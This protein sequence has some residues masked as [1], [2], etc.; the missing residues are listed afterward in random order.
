M[1]FRL[2]WLWC[3]RN[4]TLTL[5]RLP[6][7]SPAHPVLSRPK[8]AI[9][10]FL[11]TLI[12]LI[13][14]P[15]LLLMWLNAPT[16]PT[17]TPAEAPKSHRPF[18]A[19][20]PANSP[21]P[22]VT[23]SPLQIPPPTANTTRPP[24][25]ADL[26]E[27]TGDLSVP[28]NR[29]KVVQQMREIERSR[30]IETVAEAQKRG[31]P[32][33][34]EHPN[35]K[36]QELAGF[37]NGQPLYFTTHNLNA[38]ISTGANVL[39]LSP[40]SLQ[41]SGIT[42]GMWDGGSGRATHQEFSA[43]SR[44][45]VKDGAP[46]IDHATHVGGTLAAA[47][48]NSSAR[49]MAPAAIVDSYDWNS[50]KSEMTARAAAAPNEEG[51]LYLSNHSYGFVSGWNYVGGS[52]SPSRLWE[53]YG[54][55]TTNTGYEFDFGRY[56]TLSRDSDALAF[57]APYYLMFRSAGNDRTE[58][59]SNG[60][61]V[62]LS[63][64]SSTVV[65]YDSTAHPAGDG[66]YRGGFDTIGFDSLAKNVVTVGSV[67]DAVTNG[68]RDPSK[69]NS[70]SFSSWGPTD[71][72]RIKPDLVANGDGVFSSLNGSNT[73]YGTY[74]GTSMSAPNAT[75]TAALLIEEYRR[76]FPGNDMRSSSLKALLIHTADDLGRPGPD[77]KFGW[78]LINGVA[79][80]DLIRDHA[81]NPLKLRLTEGLITSTA[82]TINH[83]FVWDGVS[84]IQATLCWTDPAGTATTT[85]ELRTPRLRNDLDL[86]IIGPT[87][88]EHLPYVMPFVGTW[89]QASMDQAATTGRNN[90]D[91]VE[92]VR[93]TSPPAPGVYRCVVTF[94]GTLANNQQHYSL[95][96]SGS[97]SEQPPPPPL[98][99]SSINPNSAY[100]IA[101]QAELTGT[102]FA[103]DT[104]IKLTR[105][106][107]PDIIATNL[108]LVSGKLRCQLNLASAT[109]GLWDVWVAN[110]DGET[111]SLPAAFT[112]LSS[113]WTE[114]LDGP[115]SGWSSQ[116]TTG[117]NA[118]TLSTAA[119]HSP[120][121]AYFAPGPASKTTCHLTSPSIPIPAN[122]TNLQLKFWHQY[123]LQAGQDGGRLAFSVDNGA[124]FDVLATDSGTTF[125]SNGY[126][127][128][129][130]SGGRPA[131]RS[132]FAGLRA[133]SGSSSGFIETVVNFTNNA[134][135]AGKNL[136]LRFSLATNGGV[137]SQGWSVDSLTLLGGS[138]VSNQAPTI[139]SP[140]AA[141]TSTLPPEEDGT[142]FYQVNGQSVAV[143]V[144]ANDD[145]GEAAL[146][147]TW[148]GSS[149]T[150]PPV[151]FSANSTN[152]AKN[153][154]ALF[155]GAG[156][157]LL[158]VTVEDA[159]GLAASSNLNLRV[160]PVATSIAVTPAVASVVFG[161]PFS[162]GAQVLDQFGS[163][164]SSQPSSFQWT[165]NGGGTLSASGTF[166]ATAAGGPYVI[167]ATSGSLSGI[168][169][170][171]VTPAPAGVFLTNLQQPFDGQPKPVTVTTSPAGLATAIS[172]DGSPTAPTEA[173]SYPVEALITDPNYQGA[174]NATLV[175]DPPTTLTFSQWAS[176]YDLEPSDPEG[177]SDGD[178]LAN[179]LEYALGTNPLQPS[180]PIQIGIEP[181]PRRSPDID[182]RFAFQFNRPIGL[183]NL[184][185]HVMATTNLTDWTEVTD[186]SITE[187]PAEGWETVTAYDNQ[188]TSDRPSFMK[189]EVRLVPE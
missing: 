38:A 107:Q 187:G 122:A 140:A 99:V 91:N 131:D 189:L 172:Y 125:A 150:G 71:D 78:G 25:L 144:T 152:A 137:A 173:G 180:N 82:T 63:P 186:L 57:N 69:A 47:G 39:R 77:Y 151:S 2:D 136:R 153:T 171:T 58:N 183:P 60:Q 37:E 119:S 44:M 30:R 104:L 59:P 168:A 81:A 4:R 166:T 188:P 11:L 139:T 67:T 106:G 19:S 112:V 42:I 10:L 184:T 89:T 35:G 76:L 145:G 36:V 5:R 129:I 3:H 21:A 178:G 167:T 127:T 100:Q 33:R 155:E 15:A 64:G 17:S 142:V 160:S 24:S 158:T 46:S 13:A 18:P 23:A 54:D 181:D 101:L 41:G 31:L 29:E 174:A 49:G 117:S 128:T 70:S 164:M 74:S 52:G 97:A 126:N 48:V 12:A 143:S 147:Y 14:I 177:D 111:S 103:S 102:A 45:V 134:K 28:G 26:L 8:S 116:A 120:T 51:K 16:K 133:W 66:V 179:L 110:P 34:L 92:Q 90:V 93:V 65:S 109:P 7:L 94:T 132:E 85:T 72:G 50:D 169:S 56:N 43:G 154:V 62:A 114:N 53:W 86:K 80:V 73:S 32:L 108:E 9:A 55:G 185:Y 27:A 83:E 88:S 79:A 98:T 170:I 159:Q 105:A 138:N 61:A 182:H 95:I 84:P 165:A 118:W 121:T 115:V 87:G 20:A 6:T 130:S 22:T 148:V 163:P 149:T 75:G 135:F 146:R 156:D 124:W 176:N 175:I 1:A 161:N 141:A 96:L 68:N 123:N 157:Y 162:F 113:L 40:Y